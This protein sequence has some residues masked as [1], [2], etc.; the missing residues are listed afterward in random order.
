MDKFEIDIRLCGTEGFDNYVPTFW[1]N[2]VLYVSI[3]VVL[4]FLFIMIK[5]MIKPKEKQDKQHIK[6]KIF[7]S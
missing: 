5:E 6:Y 3:A 7:E 1:D 4:I 2:V